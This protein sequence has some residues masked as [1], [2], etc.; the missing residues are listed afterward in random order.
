MAVEL[1][2]LRSLQDFVS[3]AQ[4]TA[5]T[6]HDR[7]RMEN[8]MINNLIYY[9]TNY[10]ICAILIVIVVGTLYPKDLIIGAVTLFVAF[11]LFGIAES[12][13]PSNTSS[14]CNEETQHKKQICQHSGAVQGRCHTHD[15]LAL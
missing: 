15:H 2:P 12:R 14:C 8:R 11:V 10:F 1:P 7:E 6:F 4:F 13:E 9:Q 3:D 5:P